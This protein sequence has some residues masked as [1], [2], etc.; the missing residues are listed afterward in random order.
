MKEIEEAM[1]KF[2]L[3]MDDM[4]EAMENAR[5]ALDEVGEFDMGVEG[6]EYVIRLSQNAR[7]KI[8]FDPKTR[9][10]LIVLPDDSLWRQGLDGRWDRLGLN[11]SIDVIVQIHESR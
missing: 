7:G 1:A 11:M 5:S 2:T 4:R 10:I 6:D 8:R 3:T 9:K